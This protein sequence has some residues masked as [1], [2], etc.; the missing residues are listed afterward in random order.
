MRVWYKLDDDDNPRF[1]ELAEREY[2]AGLAKIAIK[3]SLGNEFALQDSG[4]FSSNGDKVIPTNDPI[5]KE[6]AEKSRK[7]PFLVKTKLYM[8]KEKKRKLDFPFDDMLKPGDVRPPLPH[9]T[10]QLFV[11]DD[12]W[13][14]EVQL[15]LSQNLDASDGPTRVPPMAFSRCSRGGKTRALL[16]LANLTYT[17]QYQGDQLAVPVFFVSFTDYTPLDDDDQEDPLKAL[18]VRIAFAGHKSSQA[19]MALSQADR[20]KQFKDFRR[21][22][23]VTE[24]DISEWLDDSPALLVV[25]E[26]NNLAKLNEK[27]NQE[28]K[29]FAEFVKQAFLAPQG[30]C[31]VFSTHIVSTLGCLGV[32][33]E[34]NTNSDRGVIHQK[35]PLVQ[36]LSTALGLKPTLHG[37]REVVYY[38]LMPGLIHD[39]YVYT[40]RSFPKWKFA[41]DQCND[42]SPE[43][44]KNAFHAILASLLTGRLKTR[45]FGDV[46]VQ[47]HA[48]LDASSSE[49][50]SEEVRWSP[51]HLEYILSNLRLGDRNDNHLSESMSK[52]CK[53]L[54]DSKESS[55]EGWE[56]L[57]VLFLLAR[58]LTAGWQT[59]VLPEF[60]FAT[61]GPLKVLYNQPYEGVL[62]NCQSWDDLKCGIRPG[63]E[64]ALSVYYPTH[65]RFGAYDAI[66]LFTESKEIKR[67]IGYQLKE[68]K[69]DAT[70][71]TEREFYR[72]FVVK[73]ASPNLASTRQGW[74]IL[75]D[76]DIE[77][78]FGVSGKYWTPKEWRRLAATAATGK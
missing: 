4:V 56:G 37:P 61:Q 29:K 58:C 26:L 55:G 21:K 20:G 8:E 76:N 40:G 78:F 30:R 17:T 72:S 24:S 60:T 75:S 53:M 7:H 68:G 25:D 49:D 6:D 5:P 18:L 34:Y 54:L 50:G 62:D 31:F 70:Q 69:S 22:Y 35:L 41:L 16:E 57:F 13:K 42:K 51:H 63:S 43:E 77:K 47:L 74:H 10:P 38:G 48:F 71:P 12:D 67:I 59:G 1:V 27:D 46:P 66:L 23:N 9:E 44:L 28:M 64:P 19:Q 3:E 45:E 36:N 39:R 11:C 65:S 73:G 32:Y 2:F 15:I 14:T 33:L 52:L